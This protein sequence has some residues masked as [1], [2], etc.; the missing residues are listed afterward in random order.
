M[1]VLGRPKYPERGRAG[2][3]MGTGVVSVLLCAGMR[4]AAFRH[5][6]FAADEPLGTGAALHSPALELLCKQL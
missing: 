1:A 2:G 4:D 3:E 5:H 6:L